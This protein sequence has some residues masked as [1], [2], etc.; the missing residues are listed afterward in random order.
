[1]EA[2]GSSEP[3]GMCR[4]KFTKAGVENRKSLGGEG[5]FREWGKKSG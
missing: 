1:M 5:Q 3:I 4:E 2:T